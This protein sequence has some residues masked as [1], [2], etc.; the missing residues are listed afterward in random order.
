MTADLHAEQRSSAETCDLMIRNAHVLTC[1]E[2]RNVFPN[3]AVAVRGAEIAAVGTVSE[4]DRRFTAAR[5]IDAGGGLVHPGLMDMHY[6]L[7]YHLIGKLVAEVDFSGEDPGPWAARQYTAMINALGDEEEYASALLCGLDM[8]KCG[9]TSIMDPGSAFEPDTIAEACA[10]LGFR[11][12]VADPWIMD[13]KGPQ[14]TDIER[15]NVNREAALAGLGA[16]LWRNRDPDSRTR[17]HISVYGMGND[18]DELRLAAKA[19]ADEAGVI[20]NMHQSQSIDD[21]EFDDRLYRRHP[22]VHHRE[23]GLLD[24][25]CLFVHMNVL[26]EDEF[27]PVVDSGMSVVWS[28]TNSWYYGAR[29]EIRNPMPTLFRRGTNVTI[30]L[31]VSKAASFGDQIYSAYLLARDQGDYLSPEDLL[32]MHTR[33]GA[34]A[35]RVGHCL[36]SLE[37]GKRA[38][39][40][41]RSADLPE[42]RPSHNIVRNHLLV[43][44]SRSVDTVL[45]DGE[46]LVKGGQLTRTDEG[47]VYALAERAATR[48]LERAG[49]A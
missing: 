22:L 30:G 47:S 5:T 34:R 41:I 49:L 29:T 3:G 1:D 20:F 4:L 14:I 18:S 42:V 31:D 9:V 7:T 6:H 38:D 19:V 16:Q 46:V 43:A 35:L 39:I 8:L 44:K 33:N 40:V 26:R 21:A 15:A 13:T 11:A 48:I 10:S 32:Q 36:G 45:V 27:D 28:P 37:P 23:I 12:S 24:A 2:Q 25:N 17:A